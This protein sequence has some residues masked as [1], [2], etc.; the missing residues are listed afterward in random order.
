MARTSFIPTLDAELVSLYDQ[1]RRYGTAMRCTVQLDSSYRG[2]VS[3]AWRWQLHVHTS[4]DCFLC[5]TPSI[6]Y[7]LSAIFYMMSFNSIR[8]SR[9]VYTSIFDL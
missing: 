2:S 8:D 7:L 9:E 5:I 6:R 1:W 3:L 4:D